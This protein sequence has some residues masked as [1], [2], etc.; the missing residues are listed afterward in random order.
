MQEKSFIN[1]QLGIKLNSYID[2]KCNV[3]F[4][5]KEVSKILGY[6]DTKQ[7]IRKH[8]SAENKIIKLFRTISV[9]GVK[10]TPQQNDSRGKYCVFINEPGFY[11]LVFRSKLPTAKMFQQIP[12]FFEVDHINN[13]N[14]DNRIKNLQLL[15]PKQNR[16]KSSSKPIISINIETGKEKRYISI[17]TAAIELDISAG[18]ISQVCRKK[19]KFLTSKKNG[20]KYTLKFLD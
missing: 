12:K 17:K 15:T 14:T 6:C 9:G 19:I 5:A 4:Q 16:Q 11:E 20:K 18:N 7:S 2:E 10:T 3:W 13:I 1:Y 8:V